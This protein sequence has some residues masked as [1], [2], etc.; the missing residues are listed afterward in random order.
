MKK[1]FLYTLMLAALFSATSCKKWLSVQP[2]D[3][4]SEQKLFDTEQ[5][6]YNALN[7][8]YLDMNLKDTYGGQMSMEMIEVMGQQYNILTDHRLQAINNYNFAHDS[9]KARIAMVWRGNYTRI[10]NVNKI[11]AVIDERKHIFSNGDNY[12]HVKGESFAL[13]AFLHFD[14][15][16]LFGPVYAV[17]SLKQSIPYVDDFTSKFQELIPAN[18]AIDKVLKDL[19]S[20][21]MYLR[22]DPII[23]SGPMFSGNPDGGSQFWRF[24]TLRMN[25]YAAI[26][27][28]ARVHLYR[29]NKTAAL[30]SAKTVIAAQE[31]RFPWINKDYILTNKINPNR[32]FHTEMLFGLHDIKLAD[33]QKNYFDPVLEARSILAPLPARLAAT[34]ENNNTADYRNNVAIWA[35]PGNGIK[36]Y[37]CFFKFSDIEHKDSLYRNIIPLIRISEMYYIAAETETDKTLAFGYLNTV[38]KN[39]GL[40]DVPLTATIAT[41]IRNEYKREFYGEGQLF[42]YYKRLNTTSIPSGNSSTANVAMTVGK[43]C[44]PL[45][46]DEI[47]YRD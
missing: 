15:L 3:K 23:A 39:R 10:A 35:I 1:H 32:I 30:E 26:A 47:R 28:K 38:R 43:Y 37:R 27:M 7:S 16:R 20:A 17:D 9:A 5:G 45:P 33:K 36:D 46:D 8:V 44:P 4:V 42:F 19:D 22:K 40:L 13:R 18:A 25:Y 21:E 2:R 14:M 12:S 31:G 34:Y 6:F 11:L 24:R 29:R 41:E